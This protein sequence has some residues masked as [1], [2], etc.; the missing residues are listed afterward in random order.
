MNPGVIVYYLYLEE[1]GSYFQDFY[2]LNTHEVLAFL[3]LQLRRSTSCFDAL[4]A[5]RITA[6]SELFQPLEKL[7][8]TMQ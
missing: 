5:H 4:H 1:F 7:C 2:H 8:K 3:Q 6:G